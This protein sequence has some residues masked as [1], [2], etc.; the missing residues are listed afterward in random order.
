MT[1]DAPTQSAS[2]YS[3]Y[4]AGD[5][6][7]LESRIAALE[8]NI[9]AVNARIDSAQNATDAEFRNIS[10][11]LK[12]EEAARATADQKINEKLEATGTGG[13]HISAI[14]SLWLFVGV[15]LSTASVELSQWMK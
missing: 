9:H 2:A 4:G 10:I 7:T 11:S 5:T 6:P 13:V 15:T 14:G 12:Q 8:K 3:I 1:L